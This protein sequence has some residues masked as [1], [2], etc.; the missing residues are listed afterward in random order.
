M[1]YALRAVSVASIVLLATACGSLDASYNR[2]ILKLESAWLQEN[3]RILETDGRRQFKA[4]KQQA[5][6]AAQLTVRRIG[7]AV[8]EQNY[9][10]GF[11]LVTAP[12]PTPL[13]M[14]EWAEV[15]KQDTE[16]FQKIISEDVGSLSYFATLDPSGKDVVGNVFI[17]EKDAKAEVSIGLRL[18]STR[19]T[20]DRLRRLQAPP[21][22]VRMGLRKFWNAF[23]I[24][25][26]S[27]VG[28]GTPSSIKPVASR[29]VKKSVSPPKSDVQ[30]AVQPGGNPYAIAVIIGNKDYGDRAPSVDFAY[31]DAEAIKQFF[32]EVLG[33]S[34]N[35]VINLRDVTRADMETV[36]GN[37]RT[38]KGKL[39]QWVRPHKS[40]VFVFYSGHGVPGLKDGREY[41]WPVD[42]NL[43]TPEISGY[44][45]ELL[46]KNLDQIEARS[47][48]VFIDACFSGESS[49]G[50]L[51]RGA[52]GVRVMPKKIAESTFTVISA[53]SQGQIASWDD[54]SSHGLF[55]KYLLDAL[56]G[57]A[58]E[59]PYGNGDGR[60]TLNKIKNYLD[61]EMTYAARRRYGREQQATVFGQPENV[62][63]ILRK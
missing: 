9:D 16:K 60:V 49:H 46:Y 37:D 44:P 25:L 39:W 58:D 38:P 36:F 23:E 57:A 3:I 8:E 32:V 33:L 40:D 28:R 7:M 41:L 29:P 34:E 48:T 59:K 17:T 14:E 54:E 26:G 6:E 21:T 43:N 61:S 53:T 55:T 10:T 1:R 62:L 18:R 13:T 11:L 24:E 15:Q 45:L 31:N 30:K 42:G 51:I 50:T 35:N 12:A 47:V 5:F 52:S 27:I 20:A 56:K 63:V 2:A 4:S 22:A 19:T